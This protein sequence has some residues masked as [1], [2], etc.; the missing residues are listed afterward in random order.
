MKL[1][2]MVESPIY[3][4]N[5]TNPHGVMTPRLGNS[6]LIHIIRKVLVIIW[7]IVQIKE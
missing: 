2:K 5:L 6:A 7:T 1:K 4:A 3:Q